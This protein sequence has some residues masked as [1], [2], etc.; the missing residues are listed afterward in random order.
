ME[1]V[2]STH[3]LPLDTKSS[4]EREDRKDRLQ[5]RAENSSSKP[6]LLD[7]FNVLSFLANGVNHCLP[8]GKCMR[9]AVLV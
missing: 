5:F 8:R 7:F 3:K 6:E 9:L 2:F 1:D 4:K